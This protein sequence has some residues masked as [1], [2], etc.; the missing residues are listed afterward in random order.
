MKAIANYKYC[1]VAAFSSAILFISLMAEGADTPAPD[2]KATPDTKVSDAPASK[3]KIV[4]VPP[5]PPDAACAT[6]S[7]LTRDTI[8]DKEKEDPAAAMAKVQK[9][10]DN[11]DL[12]EAFK[13]MHRLAEQ[14]YTPAQALLGEYVE[15]AMDYEEAVGWFIMA[16]SQGDPAGQYDLG[17]MYESGNGID[18]DLAKAFYWTRQSARKNYLAAV[19]KMTRVYKLGELG[20]KPDLEQ[21]KYWD[22]KYKRLKAE[23]DAADEAA[24]KA[25]QEEAKKAQEEAKKALEAAQKELDAKKAQEAAKK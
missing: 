3:A 5:P 1:L 20:Q 7:T 16:A 8:S 25:A 19:D 6:C 4:V 2:T 12:P 10:L 18:R 22:T 24:R 15:I 11:D 17:R 23:K 14:N 9:M 21:V 13:L